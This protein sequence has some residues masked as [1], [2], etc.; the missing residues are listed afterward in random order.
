MNPF[1]GIGVVGIGAAMVASAA[2]SASGLGGPMGGACEFTVRG[3]S[4]MFLTHSCIT[5][6]SIIIP[7]GMTLFGGGHTITAVDPSGSHFTGG[8]IENGGDVAHVRNVRVNTSELQ[9]TCDAGADRLRGI[10]FDGAAGSITYS[11]VMDINQGASGCQEGN[12]I[13]VRNAPFDGTHPNTRGVE[14][15]HNTVRDYQKTGIV[16][17]GDVAAKIEHNDVSSSATQKNLAANGIQL[18][19]GASGDVRQ[20]RIGGN[21]WC[22][23]S[24][25]VA[26]AALLF[27]PGGSVSLERNITT[28][29]ADVGLYLFGDGISAVRNIVFDR[30]NRIEDCNQFGYDIGI[31]NYGSGNTVNRNLVKGFDTPIDGPSGSGNRLLRSAAVPTQTDADPFF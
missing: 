29:N 25:F 24:E 13:E 30:D 31:G 17:N 2:S 3:N 9:N 5:D 8:V 10:L 14:I 11:R 7:D 23:P 16:V 26:T 18:G 19:F 20:N 28:N 4:T 12:G 6:E 15:T 22:G 21:Q 1:L 27:S